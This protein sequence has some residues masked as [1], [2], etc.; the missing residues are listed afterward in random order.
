[1]L[2]SINSLTLSE[3]KRLVALKEQIEELTGELN[4]L[5]HAPSPAKS[6]KRRGKRRMSAATRA[7]LSAGAKARWAKRRSKKGS[8]KAAP[9]T[10]AKKRTMSAATKA[11][12]AAVA[13]ARW[14]KVKAK[15][16]SRL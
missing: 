9:S 8:A 1:M 15:G 12:L 6:A 14:A 3:L 2:N 13:R 4:S 7:R 11:K 5:G 10:K 16:K